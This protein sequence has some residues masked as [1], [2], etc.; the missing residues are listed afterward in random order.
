MA[1]PVN[2]ADGKEEVSIGAS[3]R[4]GEEMSSDA[5]RNP[6][7]IG[8]NFRPLWAGTDRTSAPA[9]GLRAGRNHY[10]AKV[11]RDLRRQYAGAKR[12][13]VTSRNTRR[14]ASVNAYEIGHYVHS[15]IS[16]NNE[17]QHPLKVGPVAQRPRA[18]DS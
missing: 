12:S 1:L 10:G 4:D 6:S 8:T 13:R 5:G 15:G 3:A 11:E 16:G 14:T 9:A 17:V 2:G 7:R 18:V